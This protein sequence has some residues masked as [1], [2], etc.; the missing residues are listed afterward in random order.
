MQPT[1]STT[2]AAQRGAVLAV[3]AP[4][5]NETLRVDMVP[6]SEVQLPFEPG[7]T[8]VSRSENS[9]VFELDNGGTVTINNFFVT[10]TIRAAS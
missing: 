10:A 7:Q 1:T 4:A 6:G 2:T 3:P 9:L 8:T 5:A